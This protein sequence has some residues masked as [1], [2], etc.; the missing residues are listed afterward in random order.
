MLWI[1]IVKIIMIENY[2]FLGI[3]LAY[4]PEA[5]K[6]IALTQTKHE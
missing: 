5:Q 1:E 2:R 6:K 4:K 3:G